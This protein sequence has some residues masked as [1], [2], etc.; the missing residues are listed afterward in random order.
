MGSFTIINKIEFVKKHRFAQFIIVLQFLIIGNLYSQGIQPNDKTT[1]QPASPL[2]NVKAASGGYDDRNIQRVLDRYCGVEVWLFFEKAHWTID[3]DLTFAPNFHVKVEDGVI[4]SIS[5]GTTTFYGTFDAPVTQVFDCTGK[6]NVIFGKNSVKEICI[7]WFGS[8]DGDS[9]TTFQK[10]LN[11]AGSNGNTI[12]LLSGKTYITS[13]PLKPKDYTTIIGYGATIHS[14]SR[15]EDDAIFLFGFGTP[16]IKGVI[17]EGIT[18]TGLQRTSPAPMALHFKGDGVQIKNCVFK[19]LGYGVKE[20]KDIGHTQSKDT[21]VSGCTFNNVAMGILS[22]ASGSVYKNNRFYNIGWNGFTH[23][24]YIMGGAEN[25]VFEGN[26]INDSAGYG[27]HVY[28]AT[29][30]INNIKSL[31]NTYKDCKSGGIVFQCTNN[32]GHSSINDTFINCNLRIFSPNVTVV[33]P[34]IT[35]TIPIADPYTA[36]LINNDN[37][38]IKGGSI[39]TPVGEGIYIYASGSN[40]KIEHVTIAHWTKNG[41]H[42]QDAHGCEILNSIIKGGTDA[43]DAAIVTTGTNGVFVDNLITST[44]YG[45]LLYCETAKN[46]YLKGNNYLSAAKNVA[47]HGIGNRIEL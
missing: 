32:I 26:Y 21:V 13:K 18:F 17:F 11:S 42:I 4:F 33:N 20:D 29:E 1:P 3:S 30:D 31:N 46:N 24:V 5:A 47:D 14:L 6:G 22:S 44:G 28:S 39:D 41:I 34:R 10:A 25:I 43:N 12:K 9:T 19:N 2:I 36:I 16:L 23:P 8:T 37:I 7:E 45:I 15:V 40:C 27:F 38:R 35:G